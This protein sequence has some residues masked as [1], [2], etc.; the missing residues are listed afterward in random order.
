MTGNNMESKHRITIEVINSPIRFVILLI[1]IFITAL[2]TFADSFAQEPEKVYRYVYAIESKDWYE[3]QKNLWEKELSK[4]PYNEDAWYSNYFANRYASFGMDGTER[5]ELLNSIVDKI[6]KT[7]PDSYLYPYLRYYN[8][9]HKIEYL[10]KAFQLNPGCADLYWELIYYYELEGAESKKKEFCERLYRS[11]DIISS[12]YDFNFNMLN[13]TEK[14]SILFTN[15]DND[16]Y[17]ALVLQEAKG[18]RKDITILNAH[19]VFVLRDY[20]KLKLAERELDID[21]EN[22][23]KE[24]IAAFLKELVSSIINK[25]PEISIHIAPTVYEEYKKEIN[26]NLF[27][28]GLGYTYSGKP[29]DNVAIIKK[30]LNNKL[31]LDHLEYDWY[32]EGHISQSM[33]DRYN[34]NYVPVFMELARSYY[35]S[36]ELELGNYWKDEALLLARKVNDE[37]TIEEIETLMRHQ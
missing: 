13:S 3:K 20:L 24:D 25:Y 14:N 19:T 15:G 35:S 33:M 36:G 4:D 12:L 8:G 7:I 6:G 10:E 27:I 23:P 31:R 18:V 1:Y 22:L 11:G 21:I 5:N 28:T 29:I 16:N 34:L 9:D 30:N 37:D 26:D 17:P 32:N 2:F